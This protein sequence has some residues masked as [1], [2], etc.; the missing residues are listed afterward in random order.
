MWWWRKSR[1]YDLDRELRAHLELEAEEQ[2]DSGLTCEQAM[3]A[4]RRVFGNTTQIKEEVR[5]MLGFLWLDRLVND[6]RYGCRVLTKNPGFAAMTV[7]TAALGIGANTAI[8]SVVHAVLLRPLPYKSAERLVSPMYVAKDNFMGLGIGDFQYAAWRDHAT[9]FD[10]IAAYSGRHLTITG[11]GEAEQL[12]VQAVTPGFL[13]VLGIAPIVGRDLASAD[14]APRGSQVALMSYSLWTRRFAGDLSILSKAITLDGKPYSVAGVL[15]RNFEF[16]DNSGASLLL[17]MTEPS[18]EPKGAVYFYNVIARLKPGITTERAEADLALINQRLK[19]EYPKKF[20]QDRAVTRVFELHYRLVGNV[21]P[22][23][24]ALSG[25]VALVLLIGCLN[26]SNLLLARAISRQKEVAVRIAL[27]AARGR[28]LRQLLTE[29]MLLASLGGT[30]GLAVAFGGMQLLR[31]IAPAGVP[32]IDDV[33][34]SGPVLAFNICIALLCGVM[35]GLAPARSVSGIDPEAALKQS[36]RSATST[37]SHRRVEDLL[38]VAETTLAVI[39]LIGAGLLIRTLGK[40]TAIAPG[41]DPDNVV[42]AEL[43]WPSWKYRTP[44]RQ[45]AI[46]NEMLDKARSGPGVTA[47]SAVACLPY[48]GFRVTSVLR[49]EG[50][51]ATDPQATD[52]TANVAVNYAAGEYFKSMGIPILEGRAL[53][54]SDIAGRPSVAVVN[55]ALARHFFPDGGAIGSRIRVEGVTDWLRIVGVAGNVKQ[56]GLASETR[57]EVFQPAAQASASGGSARYLAIRAGDPRILIPWLRSQIASLDSDLPQPEIETMG[58][59]MAA[60]AAS[61]RFVMRLLTL[62]AAVAIALAAIGIYSVLVYSV[63]R[64][65]HEIAIR[66]ALGA[67]RAHIMGSVLG[68][69]LRLSLAGALL[70]TAGGLGLTSYLKSLLYGVTPHDPLTLIAGCLVVLLVALSAA[71]LPA[72]RAMKRDPV[73]TL[74]AE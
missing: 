13:G 73:A 22:A 56:R 57:A 15:P 51:P 53:D 67:K 66:L 48:G 31:A 54:N 9:I 6:L 55:E 34:L 49:I 43:S 71:Y 38:I 65:A 30:A 3:Y 1:E 27:G 26:I 19:A 46:L 59:K 11:N 61:Q 21:Q 2:H 70:G 10:G 63:E 8:F 4:A 5:E 52:P 62:F 17:A 64:R 33:H 47:A 37:R 72:R 20:G 25:A 23:L 50:K 45:Q 14:A 41:F 60:L 44:E 18:A 42:T 12:R 68:R 69:G 35:F 74:R 7:L 58:R 32:H 24:L 40:L 28:I 16:P 39:L 29:G 36:I